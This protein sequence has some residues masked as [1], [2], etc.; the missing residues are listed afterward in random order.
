MFFFYFAADEI[1]HLW[2]DT[3]S[4]V[5]SRKTQLEDM[6][7]ECR[8]FDET[9]SAFNRWLH[10]MEDEV[11]SKSYNSRDITK[12]LSNYKVKIVVIF[13]KIVFSN[14]DRFL[15]GLFSIVHS[16]CSFTLSSVF[17]KI[18]SFPYKE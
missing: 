12:S 14:Y 10:Q 11:K 13:S 15:E 18:T 5:S 17:R 9:Y 7:L 8:Q 3:R 1:S 2:N 16:F 6:V 4:A